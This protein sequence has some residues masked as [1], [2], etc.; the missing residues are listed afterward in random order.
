MVVQEAKSLTISQIQHETLRIAVIQMLER[1]L[2]T[3]STTE[4]DALI[5]EFED[6]FEEGRRDYRSPVKPV[7]SRKAKRFEPFKDL[8]KRRFL[9]YYECYLHAITEGLAKHHDGKAFEKMPFEGEGNIMKGGF[10][11]TNLLTRLNK[12]KEKLDSETSRWAQ[13]GLVAK[14]QETGLSANLIRQF[15]Q[16]KEHQRLHPVFNVDLDLEK[17]NPFVWL[18][19]YFGPSDTNLDGGIFRIRISISTEFPE[20]QPRVKVETPVYHH[21]VAK[22]GTLC[23]VPQKTENLRD[24]VHC[25]IST[26][27]DKSPPFDPRTNVHPEATKLFWGSAE[28]KK[29]YNRLQRRSAARSVEEG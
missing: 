14:S 19:T 17:G 7:T 10:E 23:Y 2:K 21:R 11:Y 8:Y 9:W 29:K 4:E 15:E 20:E 22:D 6:D 27:Q 18:L 28:D 25:I 5:A 26:L 13:E 3:G 24:H 16:L 12:I 1:V